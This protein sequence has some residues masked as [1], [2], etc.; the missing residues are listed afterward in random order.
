[1]K[2]FPWDRYVVTRTYRYGK[3]KQTKTWQRKRSQDKKGFNRYSTG[4]KWSGQFD[5]DK[6]AFWKKWQPE[7]KHVF[8]EDEML[9]SGY[10]KNQ[11]WVA[12]C[13]SWN[14]LCI[15]REREIMLK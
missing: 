5:Y 3:R 15:L 11:A 4:L 1:M 14:G 12:L 6:P 10:S 9:P 2:K 7:L 13:K 8:R